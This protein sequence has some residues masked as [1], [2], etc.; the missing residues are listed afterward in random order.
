MSVLWPVLVVGSI[1]GWG[2]AL[3]ALLRR[4]FGLDLR[5]VA[6]RVVLGIATSVFA[7]GIALLGQIQGALTPTVLGGI[8]VGFVIGVQEVRAIPETDR[9]RL[10]KVG[11]IGAAAVGVLAIFTASRAANFGWML[12]DDPNYLYL[13]RR[14]VLE[15]DLADPGNLRRIQSPGGMS[16]IQAL[17]LDQLGTR[18]LPFADMFLG[19]LLL[20]TGLWR[21]RGGRWSPWGILAAAGAIVWFPS[22]TGIGFNSS[23]VLIPAGLTL[24]TVRFLTKMRLDQG[25]RRAAGHG[26]ALGLVVATGLTIRPQ[27]GQSLALLVAVGVMWPPLDARFWR[28]A[29]GVVVGT[30]IGLAPWALVSWRDAA[31]P[32]FPLFPGNTDPSFP[33]LGERLVAMTFPEVA[34]RFAGALVNPLWLPVFLIGLVALYDS[35]RRSEELYPKVALQVFIGALATCGVWLVAMTIVGWNFGPPSN[36][37]ITRYFAP[38]FLGVAL[39]PLM[40]FNERPSLADRPTDDLHSWE[41]DD[42]GVR[43]RRWSLA[44]VAVLVAIGLIAAPNGFAK[45]GTAAEDVASGRL[46]G[47]LQEDRFAADRGDYEAALALVPEGARVFTA[48]DLPDSFLGRGRT[49]HTLDQIG[50]AS[51][52]P[53]LRYFAGDEVKTD[54]LRAHGYQY[55]IAM[56]PLTSACLY[57]TNTAES[58]VTNP[59]LAAWGAP[60]APYSHDWSDYV[61]R[62]RNQPGTRQIGPL[63][64]VPIP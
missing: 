29:G 55:L 63:V 61:G 2:S 49:I 41:R 64:V 21:T 3:G 40:F 18:F 5:S 60:W 37:L 48:V 20:L 53:H 59:D 35:Y 13:A 57:N 47:A 30:V 24:L 34:G 28:R 25:G 7:V 44:M 31:T 45:V 32:L 50:F 38:L 42:V 19:S 26:V 12:C 36:F 16:A 17:Y 23:P 51:L 6:D 62:L 56:A 4:W 58:G 9:P 52:S 11:L 27:I 14:I 8:V 1:L 43:T 54:W 22:F 46:P 15:G 39:S 33:V 10:A